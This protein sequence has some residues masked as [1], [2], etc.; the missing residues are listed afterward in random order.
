MRGFGIV[1]LG[2]FTFL[3][4]DRNSQHIIY[5]VI[6]NRRTGLDLYH[7]VKLLMYF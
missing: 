6:Y 5:S 7:I 3:A 2:H 4:K 1:A